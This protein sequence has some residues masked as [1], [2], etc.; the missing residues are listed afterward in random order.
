MKLVTGTVVFSRSPPGTQEENIMIKGGKTGE[1]WTLV[2]ILFKT[3]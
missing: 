2:T 1:E 3:I